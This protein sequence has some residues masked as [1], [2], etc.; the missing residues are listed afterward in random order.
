M[1]KAR[2]VDDEG[3]EAGG[4]GVQAECGHGWPAPM[5]PAREGGIG[6]VG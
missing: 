1:N 4:H 5:P 3:L 2:L 6:G